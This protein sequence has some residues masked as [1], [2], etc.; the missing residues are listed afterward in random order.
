MSPGRR[1]LTPEEDLEIANAYRRNRSVAEIMKTFNVSDHGL[2]R[3][4]DRTKTPRRNVDNGRFSIATVKEI[5]RLMRDDPS[6][7]MKV[8]AE[9]YGK[10]TMAMYNIRSGKSYRDVLPED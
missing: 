7:S 4:L 6:L 5:K 10:T 3:S 9:K 2:Y 8:L 1:R